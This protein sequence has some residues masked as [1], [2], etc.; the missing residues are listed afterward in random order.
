MAFEACG[1]LGYTAKGYFT[2]SSQ[3]ILA[4][5]PAGMNKKN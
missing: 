3:K 2:P 5:P 4:Q 1:F